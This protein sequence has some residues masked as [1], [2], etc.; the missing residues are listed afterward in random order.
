M[1]VVNHKRTKSRL[2]G[3]KLLCSLMYGQ[4]SWLKVSGRGYL[5]MDL[6][7]AARHLRVSSSRLRDQLG[8]LAEKG[9]IEINDLRRGEATVRLATPP[10]LAA[11]GLA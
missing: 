7:P 6:G 2:V 11:E 3:Y 1:S 9:L 10:N 8:W 4:F 5:L